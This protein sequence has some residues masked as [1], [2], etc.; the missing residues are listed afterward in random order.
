MKI[1]VIS[2]THMP[3]MA[4]SLPEPLMQGLKG[5]DLIIHA[6]DW[7]TLDVYNSLSELAPVKGVVGN[8]DGEEIK[9]EF[10][11]KQIIQ[12][13]PFRI[14]IIHGHGKKKTTEK[15]AIEAFEGESVDMI[16]FGHSH[17]PLKKEHDG[18]LLFNPGSPIDK[19][20]QPEY[21]YGMVTIK[22]TI[23][24]EHIFYKKK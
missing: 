11:E 3:G 9:A 1:G 4:K 7:K 8:I 14:G 20:R 21:S 17:I 12:A 19:R 16:I 22:D 5:V 23:E 13:G 24:A 18:V 10:P 6:G 15:R 2:D